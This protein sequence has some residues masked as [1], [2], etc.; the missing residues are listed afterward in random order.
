MDA[1]EILA[2]LA[3]RPLDQLEAFLD[4]VGEDRLNAHPG[5]HPNSIGWLLW[6]AGREV[7]AQVA[8]LAGAEETWT[9]QG[10]DRRFGPALAGAG[11]GYGHSDAQA[12][13]VVV[14]DR[15][16]LRGYLAAV[17]RASTDYLATL[18]A[19]DLAEVVDR[20]W[21]PPVTRGVRL[22][23]VFADALQHIGQAA[24]VAG[25]PDAG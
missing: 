5:G 10:W 16:L 15:E 18:T 21:D 8:E 17:T 25:M 13:A 23:S 14:R 2:D 3:R 20:R 12:R 4:G 22:V 24:Y 9:A 1:L 6:H 11:Y 7:D 19:A